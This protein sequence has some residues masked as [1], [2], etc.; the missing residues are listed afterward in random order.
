MSKEHKQLPEVRVVLDTNAIYNQSE[1]FLL[2]REV[3]GF[4]KLTEGHADL[5]LSWYLPEVVR[6]ERQ[7]QMTQR[8]MDLL[9]SI[10]KLERLLG[11]KLGI[12]QQMVELR[13]NA[14]IEEQITTHKLNVLPLRPEA[15]DWHGVMRAAAYRRAPFS[16]TEKEKGFRDALIAE[17]FLHLVNNSPLAAE[18]CRI[19]LVTS[20]DLLSEAVRAR[21]KDRTNVRV[22]P[23]LEDLKGLI[24][25]LV[26][27]VGEEVIEELKGR[28]E[29]YF[30]E[31]D[32]PDS[33][34]KKEHIL[35]RV[36]EK[37]NEAFADPPKGADSTEIVTVSLASPRFAKKEG[38][39]IHWVTRLTV[40]MHAYEDVE[41]PSAIT[42]SLRGRIVWG[43]RPLR[44]QGAGLPG[45]EPPSAASGF[46]FGAAEQS[47]ARARAYVMSGVIEIDVTW[48]ASMTAD[49]RSFSSP[50]IDVIEH[51]ATKWGERAA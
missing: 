28:A 32:N 43:S 21:T 38:Q 19:V 14:A 35:E 31:I 5:L 16:R 10:D 2:R 13:V 50:N 9:P 22:L 45:R 42:P 51:V 46:R 3:V 48:S 44:L 30:Y 6:H 20:D 33:L 26:S 39:R 36:H 17:T 41:I 15:I 11:Q 37:F 40:Q 27:E 25:T 34:Y 1:S 18:V 47:T 23:S 8:A 24:E 7:F 4:I 29:K 12:T 49:C